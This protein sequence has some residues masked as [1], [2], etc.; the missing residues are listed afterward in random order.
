MMLIPNAWQDDD[1]SEFDRLMDRYVGPDG[2]EARGFEWYYWNRRRRGELRSVALAGGFPNC[3]SVALSPDGKWVAAVTAKDGAGE[4]RLWDTA[5]GAVRRKLLAIPFNG[6]TWRSDPVPMVY[7]RHARIAF[8]PDGRRVVL[9]LGWR[10]KP[11]D[12]TR[13][14]DRL[15]DPDAQDREIY[16]WDSDKGDE[17]C[18]LSLK[19]A[20]SRF[21]GLAF[22]PGGK[23]LAFVVPPRP[24]V[25]PPGGRPAEPNRVQNVDA[26][27]P[28]FPTAPGGANVFV[29]NVDDHKAAF[30]LSATGTPRELAFRPDGGRI[31]IGVGGYEEVVAHDGNR[32]EVWDTK[33]RKDPLA[34]RNNGRLPNGVA[35]SPD[36]TR[37]AAVWKGPN[38]EA[39]SLHDAGTGKEIRTPQGVVKTETAT[40]PHP[41]FSADG[42]LLTCPASGSLVHVW[43]AASGA[44]LYTAR[45]HAGTPAVAFAPH[46]AHLLTAGR[47]GTVKEWAEPAPLAA[48]DGLEASDALAAR[49]KRLFTGAII[50]ES[51]WGEMSRTFSPLAS[52]CMP[53]GLRL[54]RASLAGEGDKASLEVRIWD[55]KGGPFRVPI[56]A[57]VR[58][59]KVSGLSFNTDGTRVVA[60]YIIPA[61]LAVDWRSGMKVWDVQSGKELFTVDG[62]SPLAGILAVSPDGSRVASNYLGKLRV[63]DVASGRVLLNVN[64]PI[65]NVA[66]FNADGSRM[67]CGM[68]DSARVWNVNAAREVLTIRSTGGPVGLLTFSPDGT[69]LAGAVGPVYVYGEVKVWDAADGREVLSLTGQQSVRD[70]TFSPDGRRLAAYGWRHENSGD[71]FGV[72]LWD[73]ASGLP[74][75]QLDSR[76]GRG[77]RRLQFQPDGGRMFLVNPYPQTPAEAYEVWDATP[78][79]GQ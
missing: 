50:P 9:S 68:M 20:G 17:L 79:G 30:T 61:P 60:Q 49:L 8:S 27:D 1:L 21:D 64:E 71:G 16:V 6:Q 67:A 44:V 12:P 33:T 7:S 59:F 25:P 63:L 43:D 19:E 51:D 57:D 26:A 70:L 14:A 31:A 40:R 22:G 28:C 23:Q 34:I 73:A 72:T 10:W 58:P 45:G 32:V 36:G 48:P 39:L 42:R 74:L 52:A 54:A 37:L 18:R 69:R 41:V 29:W 65:I 53:N 2:A 5:T 38:D 76:Q 47:D 35:F 75:L 55:E 4:F 3:D 46:G 62:D 15:P 66:S 13:P 78:T 24:G 11:A 77:S 56:R